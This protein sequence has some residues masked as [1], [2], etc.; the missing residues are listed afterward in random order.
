MRPA[1]G[2]EPTAGRRPSARQIPEKLVRLFPTAATRLIASA[3]FE[4]L[5]WRLDAGQLR[6]A[7][8]SLLE[9]PSYSASARRIQQELEALPGP[10][11]V[12]DLVEAAV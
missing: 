10:T 6:D 8:Q 3:G 12:A 1:R 9:Y 11:G 7:V 2:I 4:N 5:A